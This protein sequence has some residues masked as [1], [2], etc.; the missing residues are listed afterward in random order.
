MLI[1]MFAGAFLARLVTGA[2]G[3]GAAEARTPGLGLLRRPIPF[4]AFPELF[5][6]DGFPH[7]HL[8]HRTGRGAVK[9]LTPRNF[10]RTVS[11][12][13]VCIRKFPAASEKSGNHFARE[14]RHIFVPAANA[15]HPSRNVATRTVAAMI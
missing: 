15:T 3:S 2:L 13:P 11:I 1:Q 5:E 4:G 10:S 8:H 9:L 14:K 12:N 6:I 7:D